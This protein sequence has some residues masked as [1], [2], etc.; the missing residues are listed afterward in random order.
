MTSRPYQILPRRL[1]LLDWL[2]F[3]LLAAGLGAAATGLLPVS[4]AEATLRRILPLLI[5]L[6]AVIVLA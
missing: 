2:A 1:G 5:F 6:A 3:A 4:Q